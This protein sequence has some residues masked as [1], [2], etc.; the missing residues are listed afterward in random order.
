MKSGDRE[1]ART[2]LGSVSP[3]D[4]VQ[5]RVED[6]LTPDKDGHLDLERAR[7]VLA[8]MGES[9]HW[10]VKQAGA[11]GLIRVVG[12]LGDGLD[13]Q[14]CIKIREQVDRA[15]AELPWLLRHQ[16]KCSLAKALLEAGHPVQGLALL[17]AATREIRERDQNPRF[18]PPA[19]VELATV[20][21]ESA[22]DSALAV[23]LMTR[24]EDVYATS[25]GHLPAMDRVGLLV[26]LVE[27]NAKLG[28]SD[29]AIE[30]FNEALGLASDMVNGRPRALAIA[31]LCGA[32]G[33]SGL[34]L[35]ASVLEALDRE[36]VR[37]VDTW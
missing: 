8:Q 24:A 34:Q 29:Q 9:K 25:A 14:T 7:D 11:E 18:D 2:V 23:E 37:Q 35:P 21:D 32:A 22:A 19:L 36:L 16:L 26:S 15:A 30:H 13:E 1:R 31:E 4:S 17:D 6:L 33:R 10:E 3:K 5:V 12:L 27:G 20:Y 28:R